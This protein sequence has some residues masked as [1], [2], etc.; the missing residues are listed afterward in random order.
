MRIEVNC[1]YIR[2]NAAALVELCIER[3]VRNGFLGKAEWPQAEIDR[4]MR[5]LTPSNNLPEG[6][7]ESVQNTGD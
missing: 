2:R 5:K 4:L 3:E 6:G 1:D 7:T